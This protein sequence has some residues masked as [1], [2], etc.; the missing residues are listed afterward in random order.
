ML[1]ITQAKFVE[2]NSYFFEKCIGHVGKCLKDGDMKK[3]HVDDV[4][5]VGGSTQ[6]PKVQQMLTEFFDGKPLCNSINTDEAVVYGAAVLAAKLGGKVNEVVQDLKLLD[7]TPLSIGVWGYDDDMNVIHQHDMSVMI[8][9]NTPIPITME[10]NYGIHNDN[11]VSTDIRIY[12]GESRKIKD[13][14]FLGSFILDAC[15]NRR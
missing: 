7:V 9:R 3:K 11:Q 10:C 6:I 13:N 5:I 8:L 1:K 12:Q 15:V 4:V 14:T 2:L